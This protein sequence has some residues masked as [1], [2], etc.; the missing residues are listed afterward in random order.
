MADDTATASTAG[1]SLD[2]LLVQGKLVRD[3]SQKTSAMGLV[4][5]FINQVVAV[6][7]KVNKESL[8]LAT[9]QSYYAAK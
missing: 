5:E 7:E 8:A 3:D 1:T 9:H 4:G 2:N 6:G